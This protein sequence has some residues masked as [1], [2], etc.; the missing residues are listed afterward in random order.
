MC[1][2]KLP[3]R[4][5]VSFHR[6]LRR[7][8]ELLRVHQMDIRFAKDAEILVLLHQLAVLRRQVKRPRLTWSDRAVIVLLAQLLPRDRLRS[9]LVSPQMI[10]DWHRSLVRWRWTYPHCRPCRPTLPAETV[11]LICRLAL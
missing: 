4:G 7:A 2:A 10:L 9:F 1:W 5:S 3:V 8:L 6:L 11:E